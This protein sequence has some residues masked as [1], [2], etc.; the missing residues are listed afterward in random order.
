MNYMKHKIKLK[1][2][3]KSCCFVKN[4]AQRRFN[5]ILARI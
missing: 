1:K 2:C 5:D 3:I 4:D